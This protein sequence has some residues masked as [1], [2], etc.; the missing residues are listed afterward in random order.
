MLRRADL[1]HAPTISWHK[2]SFHIVKFRAWAKKNR[3]TRRRFSFLPARK[4]RAPYSLRLSCHDAERAD[5]RCDVLH[6][7]RA[8]RHQSPNHRHAIHHRC[9][10]RHASHRRVNH[11]HRQ[12]LP[13]CCPSRPA[14]PNRRCQHR[15]YR[16]D[17]LRHPHQRHRPDGHGRQSRDDH[18]HRR[19]EP[20]DAVQ[21][22]QSRLHSAAHAR[23]ARCAS[24]RL[25][26]RGARG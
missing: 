7:R 5:R 26:Q 24:A 17:D 22:Q 20:S 2:R 9:D 18:R 6:N 10:S 3:R 15:R 13:A 16:S 8:N 23:N 11:E 14:W 25:A 19:P 4:K 21:S 12:R 1:C